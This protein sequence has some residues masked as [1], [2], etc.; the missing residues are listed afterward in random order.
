MAVLPGGDRLMAGT[1]AGTLLRH[2]RQ[3]LAGR[4]AAPDGELLERFARRGD[5]A[6]FAA[7]MQRHGP[8]V[9]GTVRRVLGR[10]QDAEDAFQATF[11]V[12]ARKA[13]SVRRAASVGS[14]LYG[15]AYRL[16]VRAWAD[17]AR[18]GRHER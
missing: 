5:E 15:V 17:A 14:F 2:V 10:E 13:R 9:W 11:L 18:R 6:A 4:C 12:L 1:S 3:L 7:L 16:A 8:L